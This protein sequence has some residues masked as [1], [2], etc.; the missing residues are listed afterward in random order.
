MNEGV[1]FWGYEE[2][3]HLVGVM[4]IQNVRDVSLI[5]HAYIRPMKQ[6]QGIGGRLLSHLRDQT[7]L[8]ILVGTWAAADWAIRFYE[9]HGFKLVSKETKDRLL[10][11]YWSIPD[12]QVETSVVLADDKWIRLHG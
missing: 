10:K 11:E 5:R 9:D 4:G 12:R 3:E 2:D 7:T 6:N 8:P 1:V